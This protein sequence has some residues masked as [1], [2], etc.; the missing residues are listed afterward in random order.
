MTVTTILDERKEFKCM[1][2]RAIHDVNLVFWQV[3]GI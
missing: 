3:D 2:D 1:N